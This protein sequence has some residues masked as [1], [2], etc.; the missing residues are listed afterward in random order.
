MADNRQFDEKWKSAGVSKGP[1]EPDLFVLQGRIPVT[2]RQFNL[3]HYFEYISGVAKS[4]NCESALELGCG[5][6]TISLYLSKY[7]GIDVVASDLSQDAVDLAKRNFETHKARGEVRIAD[8]FKLPFADN[9]FDM[10]VSIGL[11]EH[12][13]NYADIYK[14]QWRVLKPGGVVISLNVP[15]KKSIQMLNAVYRFFV[16]AVGR[17]VNEDYF[18]NDDEPKDFKKATE[19]AGFADVETFYVNSFP[20]FTPMSMKVEPFI[21]LIYRFIYVLRGIFMAYPFKGSKLFSQ[22]HFLIGIKP[23]K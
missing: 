5:R 22:A 1:E 8:A 17:K 23:G 15:G 9:S 14:E 4:R 12:F 20:L 11:V 18:R 19:K 7:L 6:G 13:E 2:Q 21:T 10:T 16:R 3:Y